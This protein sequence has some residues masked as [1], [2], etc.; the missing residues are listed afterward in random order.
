M[1]VFKRN[2]KWVAEVPTGAR[3]AKGSI[4]RTRRIAANKTEAK[5]IER[6]LS[7]ERDKGVLLPGAD[8]TVGSYLAIWMQRI[9]HSTLKPRT[10][11]SYKQNV[12]DHIIP[13]IGNIRLINLHQSHI[14]KLQDQLAANGLG[15]NSRRIVK[16]VLS[17]AL[18]YAERNDLVTRNVAKLA[19]PIPIPKR[20]ALVIEPNQVHDLFSSMIGHR[21]EDL[22]HLYAHTGVRRG[23]GLGI[24]WSDVHLDDDPASIS[25]QRSWTQIGNG[26]EIT[27]PKTEGSIR[28]VPISPDLAIRLRER[29][30]RIIDQQFLA[31]NTDIE[32]QYVF[33]SLD[34]TP[35]RPDTVTKQLA[36]IGNTAGIPK[37][38]PHQLRHLHATMIL[39]QGLDIAVA[40]KHLGHSNI[41]TTVNIYTHQ[42]KRMIGTVGNSIQQAIDNYA[43]PKKDD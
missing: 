20:R 40:S 17:T 16:R 21:Y 8:L 33:A 5:K 4:K 7:A 10:I 2:G 29:K 15:A 22:Y 3:T 1:T 39:E 38:G 19:D 35:Y 9:D 42:T 24:T 43:I 31:P 25:I 13:Q 27:S 6:Q 18:T 37:L 11:Q 14:N 30:K 26:F 12:R 28:E 41:G 34:G 23:E 32:S 36:V